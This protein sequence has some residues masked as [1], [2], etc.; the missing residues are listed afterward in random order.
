MAERFPS[1]IRDRRLD[2]DD[3]L[4]EADALIL[5]QP[6]SKGLIFAGPGRAIRVAWTGFGQLGLWMKPGA[7][8]LCIEP[9]AGFASP[10]GFDGEFCEK[11][12]LFHLAPGAMSA[13]SYAVSLA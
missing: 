9:W 12:G 1:P 2:L 7:G 13:F 8:Y 6:A 11:P 4:F 3:S 10:E 5:D